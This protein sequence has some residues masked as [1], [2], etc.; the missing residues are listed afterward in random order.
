MAAISTLVRG[1]RIVDPPHCPKWDPA[2]GNLESESLK[3][4][5]SWKFKLQD[6]FDFK[7]AKG[8]EQGIGRIKQ[9]L[10]SVQEE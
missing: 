5:E 10:V 7:K 2:L 9:Q 1:T 6:P 8:I 3:N 4:L